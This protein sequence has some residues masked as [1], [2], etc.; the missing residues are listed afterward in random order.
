MTK[1][2]TNKEDK[3]NK[4]IIIEETQREFLSDKVVCDKTIN[5]YFIGE[6]DE[7]DEKRLSQFATT[8]LSKLQRLD[9]ENVKKII[10]K[11][12]ILPPFQQMQQEE[13]FIDQ[14]LQLIPEEGEVIAE[15][16]VLYNMNTYKIFIGDKELDDIREDLSEMLENYKGDI[17]KIS[18]QKIGQ[19]KPPKSKVCEMPIKFY[20]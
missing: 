9:R 7:N 4:E 10:R 8:L 18:I 15:G 20:R 13:Y 5:R 6:L 19:E 12:I 16:E 14:I 3:T 1:I 17:V 2:K 11:F